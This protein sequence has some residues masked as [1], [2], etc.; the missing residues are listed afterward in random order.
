MDLLPIRILCLG[1]PLWGD[2]A[3]GPTVFDSLSSDPPPNVSLVDG[4]TGGLNL[5]HWIEGAQKV[6]IVDAV[7]SGAA[8]GTLFRVPLHEVAWENGILPS[9][10]AIGVWDIVSMGRAIW[11]TVPPLWLLGME[12]AGIAGF[13]A[14]LSPEVAARLPVL[15]REVRR[16]V[17]G[18]DGAD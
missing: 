5:L 1:N 15:V 9:S 17:S 14:G 18:R 13:G 11:G 12:V 10:H 16:E 4:G 6:V 8:V 7:R 3:L 2:D